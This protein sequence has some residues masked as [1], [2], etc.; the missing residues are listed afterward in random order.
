MKTKY[1][2]FQ[3]YVFSITLIFSKYNIKYYEA[4]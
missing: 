3:K 2:H 1:E 4:Q